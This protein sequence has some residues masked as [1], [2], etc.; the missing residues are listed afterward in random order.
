MA[1]GKGKT[2]SNGTGKKR[3]SKTSVASRRGNTMQN[4][5]SRF[6]GSDTPF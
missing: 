4:L 2:G 1:K 5:S 3:T 6:N